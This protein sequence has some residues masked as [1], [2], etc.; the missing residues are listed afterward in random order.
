MCSSR[1]HP[2]ACTKQQPPSLPHEGQGELYPPSR[3]YLYFQL[4]GG[5]HLSTTNIQGLGEDTLLLQDAQGI[6]LL[7]IAY[8]AAP[9]SLVCDD[10]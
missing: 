2:G 10:N 3:V 9:V 7:P 5:P 6:A 8:A 1:L 4:W